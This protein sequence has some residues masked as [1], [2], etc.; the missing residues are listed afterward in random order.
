MTAI[1]HL[2]RVRAAIIQAN[3]EA[4]PTE[5]RPTAG[6]KQAVVDLVKSATDA[7]GKL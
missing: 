2:Q 3:A 1:P 4:K 6:V 7:L 5:A